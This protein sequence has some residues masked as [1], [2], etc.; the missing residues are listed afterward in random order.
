[1]E[2]LEDDF[3]MISGIQHFLFCKRQWALIH[4]EQKWEENFLTYEGQRLHKK[5]DNPYIKEK[6]GRSFL[7]RAMPVH[8]RIYGL[9]GKCDVVEF[10]ESKTG[11]NVIGHDGKYTLRPIEYKHGH[12]K[13][14]LSDSLQ[15]LGEALCI[16]EMMQCEIT[17]GYIYYNE[18]KHKETI[19][20]DDKLR[21]IL[22]KTIE[23]MH[24]YWYKKYTPKVKTGRWCNSCS[25]K[26]VCLPELLN[27]QTVASYLDRRLN[28]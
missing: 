18:T 22:K 26:D 27:R 14:D 2:Y 20:F 12:K 15:L 28:E 24:M 10:I 23:E 16:E 17:Q 3:L 11:I 19:A 4:V 7:V 21:S 13:Y 6:R 5:A 25:L 1:M 8:S 9:T